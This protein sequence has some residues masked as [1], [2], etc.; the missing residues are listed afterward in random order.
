MNEDGLW[1]AILLIFFIAV[2]SIVVLYTGGEVRDVGIKA[3][4]DEYTVSDPTIDRTCN[5]TY[6]P[7][8]LV[9]RWHNGTGWQV[10]TAAEYTLTGQTLVV[11]AAAMD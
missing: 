6:S 3:Q 8:G 1:I 7:S 4:T 5:L 11:T 2:I 10:L 9:V